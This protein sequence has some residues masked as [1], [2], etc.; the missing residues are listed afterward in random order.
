M[1]LIANIP[2]V[3]NAVVSKT[4]THLAIHTKAINNTNNGL[5]ETV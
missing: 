1:V 2:K 5:E 4:H 3:E